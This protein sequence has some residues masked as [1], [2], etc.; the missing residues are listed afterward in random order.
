MHSFIEIRKKLFYIAKKKNSKIK[1]FKI[2]KLMH[3]ASVL[4]NQTLPAIETW[5]WRAAKEDVI[6]ISEDSRIMT[7]NKISYLFEEMISDTQFPPKL[8]LYCH[9]YTRTRESKYFLIKKSLELEWTFWLKGSIW[10]FVDFILK[11]LIQECSVC[12][13]NLKCLNHLRI[14]KVKFFNR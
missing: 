4:R 2:Y 3:N 6:E 14:G 5:F 9:C 8:E 1:Y 11:I 10:L 7:V 12:L 13:N